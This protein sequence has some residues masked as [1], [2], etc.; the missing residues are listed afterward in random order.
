VTVGNETKKTKPHNE[1]GKNPQWQETFVFNERADLLRVVVKDKDIIGS[2]TIGEG[3]FNISRAY[4]HP[5]QVEI[6]RLFITQFP[7]TSVTK[8]NLSDSC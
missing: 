6:C 3:I 5:N 7:S 8:A 2:E 4:T 1:G